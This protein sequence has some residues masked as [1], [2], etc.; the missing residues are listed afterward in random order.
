MARAGKPSVDDL[1]ARARILDT[2]LAQF[3]AHGMRGTTIRGVAEAAGV[4]P[5]LVHHH[6]GSKQKLREAC[7]EHV[8]ECIR[9]IQMQAL[10]I[11]MTD[12]WDLSA[13]VQIS[14]PLRRYLARALA[15]RS[16]SLPLPLSLTLF[17]EPPGGAGAGGDHGC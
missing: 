9:S 10:E 3:A 5:G 17:D 2:A 11:G 4:S 8:M 16:L 7:D 6:F 15:E 1:T 13:V 12:P 14:V